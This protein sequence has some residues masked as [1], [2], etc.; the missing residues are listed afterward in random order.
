MVLAWLVAQV[1]QLVFESF[2]TPGWAIKTLLVLL[3]TGL[4]F[5]LFFAWAFEMTPEGIKREHEVDRSQSITPQ[6]GKKLNFMI[7]VVMALALGYF[8]YDKFVLSGGR[9]TAAV[10]SAVQE[11]TS[12]AL[13]GQSAGV[14]AADRSIAVLPFV[15]MSGDQENEYFSDGLTEELLNALAKVKDLKVTGR[16]SSFAFK[17]QNA[18]LRDIGAALNVAHILEGSVRKAQNRVRITAQLINVADGYHLWSDTYNRELDD[19]F[20]IQEEIAT[21]VVQELSATLLGDSGEQ[22]VQLG[23]SNTKAYEL[24]LHGRYV[25]D[26]ARDDN[27]AQDESDAFFLRAIELDPEFTLAWYGRFRVSDYRHRGGA[28]PFREGLVRMRELADKLIQMDP[29]LAESQVASGRTALA[30]MN[31]NLAGSA[32]RKALQLNP[33]NIDAMAGYAGLLGLLARHAEKMEF[34]LKALERDPL[35]LGALLTAANGFSELGQ[36]DEVRKITEKALSL[37]PDLGRF[38]G[39]LGACFLWLE[40]KPDR[41][42]QHLRLEPLDHIRLTGLAIAYH[43]LGQQDEAQRQLDKLIEV[44]GENAA[45]QYA[46]IYAQWGESDQ[47]LDALEHAWEIRDAG[48]VLLKADEW[49]TPLHDNPRFIALLKKWEDPNKR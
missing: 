33:G 48:F 19:I 25:F 17:G 34:A 38:R 35:D 30:E 43:R 14:A 29:Q 16:T 28:V 49:F 44:E 22:L 7:I 10:E 5:A 4:P 3:A 39:T 47:A 20:A 42:I 2:G 41:A 37:E 24:Y 21:K 9:E 13:T 31:W 27:Q 26:R 23:T 40:N 36:C 11:A 15:N 1:L 8:A 46:Q 45:Y 18:D 12:Q 6:T 32:Y